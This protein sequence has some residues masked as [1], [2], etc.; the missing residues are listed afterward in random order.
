[1]VFNLN[2]VDLFKDT[3]WTGERINSCVEISSVEVITMTSMFDHSFFYI[4]ILL[5]LLA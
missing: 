1:M 2:I 4:Y 5:L 3:R